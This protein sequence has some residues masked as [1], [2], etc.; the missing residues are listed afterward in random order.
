VP[1][2]EHFF[3]EIDSDIYTIDETEI[4]LPGWV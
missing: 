2:F 3:Q 1:V 4:E